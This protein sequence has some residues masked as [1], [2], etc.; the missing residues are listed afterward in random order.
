MVAHV[1]LYPVQADG[2]PGGHPAMVAVASIGLGPAA[3]VN[4]RRP[5]AELLHLDV[6]AERGKLQDLLQTAAPIFEDS[7]RDISALLRADRTV[8]D[9]F[10]DLRIAVH[11]VDARRS[12]SSDAGEWQNGVFALARDLLGDTALLPEKAIRKLNGDIFQRER[13]ARLRA[14]Y[15]AALFAHFEPELTAD[16]QAR[17]LYDNVDL[18]LAPVV[19]MMQERGVGCNVEAAMGYAAALRREHH[20][21][22]ETLKSSIANPE[23]VIDDTKLRKYLYEEVGFAPLVLTDKGLPSVSEAALTALRDPV[24]DRIVVVR[25]QHMLLQHL[26]YLVADRIHGEFH[27]AGSV[28]GRVY[29]RRPNLVGLPREL[30]R[31]I[32]AAPGRVLVIADY[33]QMELRVLAALA[34]DVALVRAF[35]NGEDL[36]RKMAALIHGIPLDVVTDEQRNGEGKVTNFAVVYGQTEPGLAEALGVTVQEAAR[37]LAL[38]RL[39]YPR[40]WAWRREKLDQARAAEGLLRT[41]LGRKRHLPSVC[42][43]SAEAA[44]KLI[45][46]QVQ[47]VAADIAKSRLR[48]AAEAVGDR[49]WPVLFAHDEFVF[50]CLPAHADAVKATAVAIAERQVQGFCV[51]LKV[52]AI[53]GTSWADKP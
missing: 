31:F 43:G 24:V 33:S 53:V 12:W 14:D 34:K 21:E 38:H 25:H 15:L 41:W 16:E 23:D 19:R 26:R 44:R 4:P 39:R 32:V 52:K 46:H 18:P 17:K 48:Q 22:L 2:T 20:V 50:E 5:R 35:I 11:E 9:H 10:D 13:Q 1:A 8:P 51:P 37:M 49:A 27:I 29:M 3:P 7:V 6:P 47:S 36:H 30:R 28:S 40:V 42:N 45:N